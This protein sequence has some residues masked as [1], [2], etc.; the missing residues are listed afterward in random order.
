[1]KKFILLILLLICFVVATL[2]RNELIKAKSPI[3]T[4][5]GTLPPDIA[6]T[7]VALGPIKGFISNLL[8]LEATD[9]Q[10][11]KEFFD[12]LQVSKWISQI[13]PNN[14]DV[15]KYIAWNMSFNISGEFSEYEEQWQWVERGFQMLRG[16]TYLKNN[17]TSVLAPELATILYTKL[18]FSG[19]VQ[20]NNYFYQK[21]SDKLFKYQEQEALPFKDLEFYK[22]MRKEFEL[23]DLGPSSS[24]ESLYY[25][26][27]PKGLTNWR[28]KLHAKKG[29]SKGTFSG[30]VTE[31]L[32]FGRRV[33]MPNG[34]WH[35]FEYMDSDVIIEE[36]QKISWASSVQ[37]GYKEL[38]YY[39]A[40]LSNR[41]DLLEK[42]TQFDHTL[43]KERHQLR[44]EKQLYP[45]GREADFLLFEAELA[46]KN[47]LEG[48][49]IGRLK[50]FKILYPNKKIQLFKYDKKFQEIAQ[51]YL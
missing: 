35:S 22:T 18:S 30:I 39:L 29:P 32:N 5:A 12:C 11:E 51:K 50:L 28:S 6:L 46:Y 3:K 25:M 17:M 36:V 24:L 33:K 37:Q 20:L 31:L 42:I 45:K 49:A 34:Q 14:P 41:T 43:L 23:K 16:K 44:L 48:S 21:Y 38:I 1:M 40:F 8:W 4:D 19:D 26:T 9:K 7:V 27:Y 47:N 15:W 2:N 10:D 13:Q